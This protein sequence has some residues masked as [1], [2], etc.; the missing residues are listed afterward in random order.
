M[1]FSTVESKGVTNISKKMQFGLLVLAAVSMFTAIA[2]PVAATDYNAQ[3][4]NLKTQNASNSTSRSN[5]QSAATTLQDQINA[6]QN[7]IATIG[8]QIATNESRQATLQQQIA[9]TQAEIVK[10]QDILSVSVRKLYIQNDMSML[11]MMASSKSLGDYV[12]REQYTV[13]AQ[14]SV[15]NELDKIN[16]LKTQEQQQ[17]KQV[18]GLL[19]D[20]KAMQAQV[21]SQKAQV[22]HLLAMNQTQQA[23]YTATIANNDS[24]I[25]DLQAQ[26]AA[27]N[28]A[29]LKQQ[30]SAAASAHA[31]A[32]ANGTPVTQ[33]AAAA[34][35]GSVNGANYPY[36]GAPWPNDIA[37]P[38]GMY[39][40]QCVSFTAWAVTASGRHMP[41]WGGR[42]DAKQWDDNA[43]AAGIPVDGNPRPGDV[44]IKNSG[45][46]G[47]AMYVTGVNSDGTINIA[48]YN[49]N[50][51]G[52]Y[53]TATI[54]PSGL[55]FI[56]F[57]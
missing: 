45:T 33:I 9:D 27:E 37:D 43:I 18:D 55:A 56:H 53:S 7:T 23:Q 54:Y 38:W 19:A 13:S 48:Q 15:K 22:D 16:A 8:D 29:F 5:L 28:E 25:T 1:K 51:D 26:Q 17:K 21:T 10:E 2:R 24:K 20:N 42:G 32:A 3:I 36:S 35:I 47:H 14:T 50:W 39:Q 52:R 49:A 6:L 41:Y 57:P 30:A 44:A 11:E 31:R 46:Y 34:N 4:Q 12:D 40:R